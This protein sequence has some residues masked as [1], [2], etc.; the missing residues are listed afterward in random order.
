METYDNR[1]EISGN[2]SEGWTTG[3]STGPDDEIAFFGDGFE[4]VALLQG[5]QNVRI[6]DDALKG[7]EKEH[8]NN[9]ATAVQPFEMVRRAKRQ[10]QQLAETS[11]PEEDVQQKFS[12]GF[13]AF[14]NR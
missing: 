5:N 1:M 6:D 9:A 2:S 13:D 14:A 10:A 4:P 3:Y 7:M 12:Q 11:D 8:G